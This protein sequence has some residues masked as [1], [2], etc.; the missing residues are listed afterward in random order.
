[1]KTRAL[2]NYSSSRG[3]EVYDID[4]NSNDEVNE[5]GKLVGDQCIVFIDQKIT[6]ERLY[7]IMSSWGEES[8][9]VIFD[10]VRSGKLTGRH[11]RE[12]K[13]MLGWVSQKDDKLK[14]SV[15]A[16]TYRTDAYGRPLG[17]FSNGELDWHSDQCA[18]DD[19]PRTIGLQSIAHTE[20]SQTTFL[21]THD[22]YES[23]STDMKSMIK[24]LRVR[25]TW[26]NGVCAPGL[27]SSQ[28][29]LV[30]ENMVPHCG[31][32][33]RL[34]SESASGLPG[35]KLPTHSFDRFVGMSKEE[36][37]RF[38]NELKTAI[39]KPEYVYTQNWVDGQLVFMDQEI[40]LHARPTNVKEG[41]MRTMARV[42]FYMNKLFPNKLRS[43]HY[44]IDG[45]TYNYEEFLHQVDQ[46]RK[47]EFELSQQGKYATRNNEVWADN[48]QR[49]S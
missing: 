5:L 36:S 25:H 30:H 42:I 18:V 1:M 24:D 45:K 7:D 47:V 27:N 13:L 17:M 40:T 35:I 29:L 10:A 12:V 31:L 9:A 49:I 11:W 22:A 33:T 39:F 46:R 3:Q 34:Y 43:D 21:C 16:I 28:S 20:N 38:Y 26:R 4:L 15:S 37:D 41:N 6:T 14:T 2:K 23:M 44:I 48:E 32:E 8:R 19:A